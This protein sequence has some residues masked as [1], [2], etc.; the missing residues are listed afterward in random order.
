MNCDVVIKILDWV[1]LIICVKKNEQL[2]TFTIKNIACA[3]LCSNFQL[4]NLKKKM[5]FSFRRN[6]K[7]F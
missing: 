7:K 3:T 1:F 5:T 2:K 4:L 6:R